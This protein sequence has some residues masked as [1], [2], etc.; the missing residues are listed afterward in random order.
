MQPRY[1]I[2]IMIQKISCL[3]LLL[4]SEFAHPDILTGLSLLAYR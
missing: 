1:L 3:I 4:A 2:V